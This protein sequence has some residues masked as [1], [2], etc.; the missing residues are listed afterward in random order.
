M[1][2]AWQHKCWE[3][4]KTVISEQWLIQQSVSYE[5]RIGKDDLERTYFTIFLLSWNRQS[6]SWQC[7]LYWLRWHL[8]VQMS[9]FTDKCPCP[10][11]IT[12]NFGCQHMVE[13]N[14]NV[15]WASLLITT[16]PQPLPL[17]STIQWLLATRHNTRWV[18]HC[19]IRHGS[20][21]VMLI[22]NPVD[23]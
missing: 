14:T 8:V 16:I 11:C 6:Y 5:T 15:A 10:H 18:D 2:K 1:W 20:F 3:H 21:K 23:I 19:H 7:L 17:E 12:T 4:S 13:C 22:L 9:L